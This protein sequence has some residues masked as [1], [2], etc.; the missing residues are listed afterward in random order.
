[1]GHLGDKG[2]S[3][4]R[5]NN[6]KDWREQSG[7]EM[8]GCTRRNRLP[9]PERGR[10]AWQRLPRHQKGSCFESLCLGFASISVRPINTRLCQKR[11]QYTTTLDPALQGY[12]DRCTSV[13]HPPQNEHPTGKQ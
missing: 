4:E 3:T 8:S 9:C 12:W 5:Q 13:P 7:D 6:K 10:N 11:A 1:M 2:G